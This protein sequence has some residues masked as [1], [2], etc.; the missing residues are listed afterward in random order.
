MMA[1]APPNHRNAV[2]PNRWS[3][4]GIGGARPMPVTD[5]RDSGQIALLGPSSGCS[6]AWIGIPAILQRPAPRCGATTIITPRKL[7]SP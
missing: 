2:R 7:K 5:G 3:S 6:A 1:I 4:T